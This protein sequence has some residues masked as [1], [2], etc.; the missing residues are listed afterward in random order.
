MIK[1][2]I[3]GY[4]YDSFDEYPEEKRGCLKMIKKS[5]RDSLFL[6]DLY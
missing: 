2:R 6:S 1:R 5:W 3:E 4:Q